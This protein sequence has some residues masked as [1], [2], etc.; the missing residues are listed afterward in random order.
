M[1]LLPHARRPEHIAVLGKTG[2][3]KSTLLKHF[4]LQD[5]EANRGFVFFDLHGDAQ[6]FL[7]AA[8][9][10]RERSRNEDLTQK[11]IVIGTGL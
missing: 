2:T 9:A 5:I 8:I 7:L 4:V 11:L 10:Q 6:S 3:G 1:S